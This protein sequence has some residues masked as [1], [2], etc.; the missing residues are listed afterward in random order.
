MLSSVSLAHQIPLKRAKFT[1]VVRHLPPVPRV[2]P[3]GWLVWNHRC[4]RVLAQPPSFAS[5]PRSLSSS[6][7]WPV[8]RGVGGPSFSRSSRNRVHLGLEFAHRRCST[9]ELR[10]CRR[11]VAPLWLGFP[12]DAEVMVLQRNNFSQFLPFSSG[13]LLRHQQKGWGDLS[14]S[15]GSAHRRLL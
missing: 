4:H 6:G 1:E 3:E 7:T 14:R 2:A 15:P 5:G 12:G 13:D 11:S 8:E 10:F 9:M